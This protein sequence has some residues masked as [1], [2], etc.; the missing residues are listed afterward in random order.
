MFDIFVLAVVG[1]LDII[2]LF[3]GMVKQLFGLVGV[4]RG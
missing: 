4:E 3:K 1:I 2:G